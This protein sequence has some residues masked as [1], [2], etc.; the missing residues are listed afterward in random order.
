MFSTDCKQ[1]ALPNRKSSEH[2]AGAGHKM[3]EIG[4]NDWI[5]D[6]NS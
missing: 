4:R 1:S 2:L 6:E 5:G 3:P